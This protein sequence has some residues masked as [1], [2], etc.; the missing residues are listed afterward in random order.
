MF[1][2]DLDK[3]MAAYYHELFSD[4]QAPGTKLYKFFGWEY[5]IAFFRLALKKSEVGPVTVRFW[6]ALAKH[7]LGVDYFWSHHDGL[8][9]N[10][11]R[12]LSA[13]I[14]DD[15]D[16]VYKL[17]EEINDIYG[18]YHQIPT[19]YFNHGESLFYKAMTCMNGSDNIAIPLRES[20]MYLEKAIAG[21]ER[22]QPNYEFTY[23]RD[24]L[25]FFYFKLLDWK[26]LIEGKDVDNESIEMITQDMMDF[27]KLLN[28]QENNPRPEHFRV[29][30]DLLHFSQI[31]Q[32]FDDSEKMI[33]S[34]WQ[35]AFDAEKMKWGEQDGEN[36]MRKEKS[37]Y[38]KGLAFH[39]EWHLK[40]WDKIRE[41][42]RDV[43]GIKTI[44]DEFWATINPLFL[45]N[46][47]PKNAIK[48][49]RDYCQIKKD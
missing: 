23:R 7:R 29:I 4:H 40:K 14:F 45:E 1:K 41:V 34:Y 35:K 47:E 22:I 48:E 42:I 43:N 49:L 20:K 3:E 39:D 32:S 2:S 6:E 30:I 21:G 17:A 10:L 28:S 46:D 19:I 11:L 26:N 13:K 25:D 38:R 8:S 36:N 5:A 24:Y 16:S 31:S 27:I 33:S 15:V 18:E 12:E 44:N 9:N 37:C